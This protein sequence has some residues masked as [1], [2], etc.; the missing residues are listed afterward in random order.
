VAS[1]AVDGGQRQ[2]G[3]ARSAG[4][5]EVQRARGVGDDQHTGAFRVEGEQGRAGEAPAFGANAG[6]VART[7]DG[8][9]DGDAGGDLARRE[10]RQP[11]VALSGRASE[12]Q[13]QRREDGA[14][15]KRCRRDPGAQR[16]GDKGGVEQR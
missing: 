9:V 16:L 11:G 15:Q 10:S 4:F 14:S 8:L 12:G 5:D 3:Q 7:D 13:G 1:R 6:S 2:D